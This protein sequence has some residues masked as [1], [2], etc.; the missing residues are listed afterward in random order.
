M[1]DEFKS[2]PEKMLS[3]GKVILRPLEKRDLDKSLEWLTDPLVNKY[4]S[5]NFKD[6]TVKQEEQWFNYIKES[7]QDMVFAILE[8][9]SDKHIGN[10]ALHKI[11]PSRKTC[12]LGIVIGEKDYWDRGYGTDAVKV[13][14]GFAVGDMELTKIRLNVYTYNHRAIKV[15]ENC[16][17]KLIRVLKRNHLFNGKYWDTLIMEYGVRPAPI[18]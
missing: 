18:Y 4:L 9:K 14:I 3:G 7:R 15:Y 2:T 1:I 11:D 8:K 13:L 10:C 5:Q 6:L 17:F 12:E 16:G